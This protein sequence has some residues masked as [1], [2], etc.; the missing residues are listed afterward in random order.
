M[1]SIAASLMLATAVTAQNV[2]CDG[3]NFFNQNFS[4]TLLNG[5]VVNL[6]EGPLL[7]SNVASF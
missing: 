3:S 7:I 2:T 6:N 1:K 5:T 4:V